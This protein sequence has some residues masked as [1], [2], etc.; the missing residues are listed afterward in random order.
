MP[1]DAPLLQLLLLSAPPSLLY[2]APLGG[3]VTFLSAEKELLAQ[4][5]SPHS[6]ESEPISIRFPK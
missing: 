6:P 1:S 3:G 5:W 4:S 2:E